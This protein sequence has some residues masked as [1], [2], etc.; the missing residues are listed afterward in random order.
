MTALIPRLE[1]LTEPS[2]EVDAEIWFSVFAPAARGPLTSEDVDHAG[3]TRTAWHKELNSIWDD[4]VPAY[5]QSI[6]AAM[7]LVDQVGILLLFNDIGAD[8]LPMAVVG[9]PD[10][11]KEF[12]A[13][14]GCSRAT[15]IAIAAL[16]AMEA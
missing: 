6:D 13:V 14:A 12:T 7:T 11:S 10:I 2:R 1:A 3:P 16:K 5:T 15:T 9:R 4:E 8:G